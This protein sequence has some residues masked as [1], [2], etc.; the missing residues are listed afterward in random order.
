MNAG[1]SGA[2]HGL[3][4]SGGRYVVT[5][6][7]S[8]REC[9][10]ENAVLKRI[11][12]GCVEDTGGLFVALEED[13]DE[14]IADFLS[15]AAGI[16]LPAEQADLKEI[17]EEEP[18]LQPR[19]K[20]AIR[21][22]DAS[23]NPFLTT[24]ANLDA[25]QR[26]GAR[27]FFYTQVT[28]MQRDGKR[29]TR[30]EAIQAKT[31]ETVRGLCRSGRQCGR[32]LG[33]SDRRP[34]RG[35]PAHRVLPGQPADHE[36][37][38]GQPGHQPAEAP[39]RWGH[40]CARGDGNDHRHQLDPRGEPGSPEDERVRG[41]PTRR[42]GVQDGACPR[43]GPFHPGVRGRPSAGSG[44]SER[45][46][47]ADHEDLYR[48]RPREGR[49][50]EPGEHRRGKAHHLSP[51]GGEGG[52]PGLP[53]ARGGRTLPDSRDSA[54]RQRRGAN[55]GHRDRGSNACGSPHRTG[56]SSASARWWGGSRSR[57]S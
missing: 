25:A 50:R 46:G 19:I 41:G 21:V 45:G 15:S 42:G 40:R 56:E 33:R 4:H 1:A 24:Q 8:A 36:L 54:S 9:A 23:I 30:V 7:D 55:P 34:R 10:R 13:K 3:L 22:P 11:A 12:S 5:D 28:S 49:A 39:F 48:V 18:S 47:Q 38:V 51:D 6:P 20:A 29:I 35:R 57:K 17:L 14:F 37:P 43:D 26:L 52:R 44:R 27:V 53:A 2:N 31:G 32:P 16:G